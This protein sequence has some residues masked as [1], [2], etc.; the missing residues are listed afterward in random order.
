MGD[1]G[2]EVDETI[3][4]EGEIDAGRIKI[5]RLESDV[6]NLTKERDDLLKFVEESKKPP[7]YAAVVVEPREEDVLVYGQHGGLQTVAYGRV[8]KEKI[9]PGKFV[10]IGN[11][12]VDFPSHS[13]R[14]RYQQTNVMGVTEIL[15]REAP[16]LRGKIASIDHEGDYD[17]VVIS[18]DPHYARSIKIGKDRVKELGLKPNMS[19]DCLPETL[20][21]IRVGK[22]V[23]MAKYEVIERPK[24]VFEDIGGL[25]EAKEE[26]VTSVIAPMI[27]PKDYSRYGKTSAKILMYG[28]PGC[29]KTMLAQALARTLNN[30]GFYRVNAAEIHEMWVGKSEENLRNIFKTAINEL[31]ER[32]FNY[33]V[34]FFDEIDALAPHRGIHPGASGVEEKVVGEFLTWL[35]GFRPL[36]SNL[37]VMAA[38]NMPGLVDAAVRQ[39]FDK[40]IEVSQPQ[41]KATVREIVSKYINEDNVPIDSSLIKSHG[42]NAW[43]HLADDLTDFLFWEDR[44]DTGGNQINRRD[45]ITGRLIS[46]TVENAK[47]L[48]LYDR[49]ILKKRIPKKYKDLFESLDSK[50]RISELKKK[51]KTAEEIGINMEYLREAFDMNKFER[52]EEIITSK[53]LYLPAKKPESHWTGL[54]YIG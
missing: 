48:A 35:E 47:E 20:D 28:P 8:D 30:C 39:R 15:E 9:K 49:T 16:L 3:R 21:I 37:I 19:V 38:T 24:T 52:A 27:N 50:D 17:I 43:N 42:S 7:N 45:I 1:S 18:T 14:A 40:L 51:Y 22:S 53:Q 31:E 41:D 33:M 29:G 44:I 5:R 6:R 12:Q 36:P 46:Q 34:L 54:S 2:D 10:L 11:I 13:Y 23:D 26:L 4:L 25:K 32:K